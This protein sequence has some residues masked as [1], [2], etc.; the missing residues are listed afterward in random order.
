MY[1]GETQDN[2]RDMR[3]NFNGYDFRL[4]NSAIDQVKLT[5]YASRYKEDT[6]YPPFFLTAPPLAPTPNPPTNPS[7]DET[8]LELPLAYT[9]TRAGFNATWQPYGNR[10]PRCSNYGLWDGTSLTTGY[11]FYQ[12]ERDNAIYKIT[13]ASPGFFAQSDTTTNQIEF[14]PSTKWS[15]E[16]DSFVRYRLQFIE[17]PLVGVSQYSI[18]DPT[19]SGTFNSNQPQQV[20]NVD[21]GYNWSPYTNFMMSAEFTIQNSWN[22]SQFAHFTETNYPMSFTVWYAPTDRLSF[23][24][25]YA[26]YSDWIDQEIT[27]GANRGIPTDTETTPWNYTG[28]NHLFTI[29]ANYA[30]SRCV[31]LMAGYEWDRGANFFGV[32]PSPNPGVDWSLLPFLSDVNVITQRVTAGIDWKPH[33]DLD[34]YLRYVYYDFNDIGSGL[35]SGTTNMI[36]AGATRTW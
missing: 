26:Y 22:E 27:L 10:G 34:M 11:E 29:N 20:H 5:G 17:N 30:W 4:T 7:Y 31:K 9:R 18:D 2:I 33:H 13:P 24:G 32:P 15:R 6:T 19:V 21:F 35:N 25:G 23:T 36:L 28:K 16:F 12:L 8:S 14:G 1:I 3:R